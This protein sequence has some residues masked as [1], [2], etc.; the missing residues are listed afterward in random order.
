[1]VVIVVM[2]R[3]EVVEWWSRWWSGGGATAAVEGGGDEAEV[4]DELVEGVV[5]LLVVHVGV[6]AQPLAVLLP[7]LDHPGWLVSAGG[8]E[9]TTIFSVL[10]AN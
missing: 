10:K 3:E 5:E 8:E 1:M 7:A 6:E 2:V 9:Q 4:W